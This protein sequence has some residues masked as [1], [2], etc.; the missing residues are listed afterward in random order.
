MADTAEL[1]SY[2]SAQAIAHGIP[3]DYF[4]RFITKESAWNPNAVSSKGAEGIAQIMP[5]TAAGHVNPFDPFAAIHFAAQTLAGYFANFGS[6]GDAFAAY[7][8]GPGAVKKYG[9]IPPYP[10]TQNYVDYIIGKAS[11]IV[12]PTGGTGVTPQAGNLARIV[13]WTAALILIVIGIRSTLK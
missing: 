1:Q 4:L 9:G 5:D 13:I 8:A 2:A 11:Q 6:W 7:N 3:V 12:H 10:E